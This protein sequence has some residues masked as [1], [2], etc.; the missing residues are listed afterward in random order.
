MALRPTRTTLPTTQITQT[1]TA[2][3]KVVESG[4]AAKTLQASNDK[5]I[6]ESREAVI[7]PDNL[8]ELVELANDIIRRGRSGKH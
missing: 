6:K 7:V 5:R 3:G 4:N 2:R 8:S 1:D